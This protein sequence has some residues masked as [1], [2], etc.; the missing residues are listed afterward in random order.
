M[1]PR[2]YFDPPSEREWTMAER[3]EFFAS[4]DAITGLLNGTNTR[5]IHIT[6]IDHPAQGWPIS[7]YCPICKE[8]TFVLSQW[9]IKP[10]DGE[11]F[12]MNNV[13]GSLIVGDMHNIE[14]E[15]ERG[16]REL[17]KY[18]LGLK[19]IFGYDPCE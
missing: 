8:T 13:C 7:M 15:L 14:M 2:S 1:E 6:R 17:L 3:E 9:G 4:Q 10:E 18:P 11:Y 12:K 19:S 16:F 5:G